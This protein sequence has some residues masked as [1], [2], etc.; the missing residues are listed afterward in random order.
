MKNFRFLLSVFVVIF[1][2]LGTPISN[3]ATDTTALVNVSVSNM[4]ETPNSQSQVISQAVYETSIK[5]LRKQHGFA[6]VQTADNYQGWIDQRELTF[7]EI[8]PNARFVKV[9]NLFAN[10]YQ[11][12]SISSHQPFLTVPFGTQL[13]VIKLSDN[14][15]WI[16]L[17][18]ADGKTGWVQSPDV[19]LDPKPITMEEML[20]LSH[21][22]IGVPYLWGGVSSYGIDCSG[23]VQMLYKQMD[24]FLP[25]DTNIQV[26]WPGFE[27]IPLKK[28]KPG[29]ILY[30][31]WDNK[32]SHTG[33]Y[34]G[35]NQFINAT[36][37][38]NPVVQISDIR[39]P[40]W[41][42]L[43][44]VARR[45]D[46]TPP[47]PPFEGSVAAVPA[48]IQQAMQ[49][50]SW[51]QGCPE[52]IENL[53]Y[54]TLS[55]WGFDNKPHQGEL[56]VHKDLAQETLDIFKELYQKKYPIE[57]MQPIDAYQGDDNAS[58]IDNNTS[59]FNCRPMTDFKNMYSVH[60]YG[61]AIDIN[62]L[63]NPY[64]NGSSIE[65]KE[66]APYA[67]RAIHQKGKILLN[68]AVYEVFTKRGWTWG[69][70]WLGPIKDYQHFEKP[71]PKK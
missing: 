15:S 66:G 64:V 48:K 10:I 68:S 41:Q 12:A 4:Y 16:A 11:D 34:L 50:Y 31:G 23:F 61:R 67:D 71:D 40:H 29:D 58:M 56:I 7:R 35:K 47:P 28:A 18:L 26:Y 59:A 3:A 39:D 36:I 17:Q 52:P 22:F 65:P 46:T 44:I 13:P 5:V 1:S 21:K 2:L 33:I 42:K 24:V 57:K 43:F 70:S 45:L 32:V 30:F 6:F 19:I 54:L 51:R 8:V 14:G 60:S 27:E 37:Y 9:K 20:A 49:K 62:P 63:I 38:G 69:G 55:Y 25:R 53:A